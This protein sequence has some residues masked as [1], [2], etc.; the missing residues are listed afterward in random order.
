MNRLP[1]A[2]RREQL[3]E[4]AL[5]VAS[6]DGIDAATVRAVAAEAGVSLGVVHYCF[7]DKAELM[8]AMAHAITGQNASGS[9]AGLP[10]DAR[11]EQIIDAV[12]GGLWDGISSHRGSQLLS[13]ELTTSSL[14]HADLAQVAKEQYEGSWTAAEQ[15]LGMIEQAAGVTWSVPRSDLAR[16]V[17]ALVDGYSLAWLVDGDDGAARSGLRSVGGY[18]A[19]LARPAPTAAPAPD[20]PHD[21]GADQAPHPAGTT[22]AP[23]A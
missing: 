10:A 3:I 20:A 11:V 17:V 14:R 16:V 21:Q 2:E 4:A 13:Y 18:L 1:V 7:Q 9:L 19:T 23:D 5:A 15:A 6:R 8:R 22:P 12:L